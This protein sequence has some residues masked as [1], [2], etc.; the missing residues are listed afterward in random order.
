MSQPDPHHLVLT[1]LREEI[2][3]LERRPA[4]REG[5]VA[6]GVASVDA[7]LPGGGFP[8]G[9]LSE[10]VGGPASGKARWRGVGRR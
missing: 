7:V 10:L 5:F 4:R 6:C 2:R 1:R 9:A 8:R 3:R